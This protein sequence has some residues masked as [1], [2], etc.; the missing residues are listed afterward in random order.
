MSNE[1]VIGVDLGGTK[2]ESCLMDKD[3]NVLSRHRIASEVDMGFDRVLDNLRKVIIKTATGKPYQAIGMGT[4]G[5][6][7]SEKDRLFGLPHTSLYEIPGFI[8]QIEK[9]LKKPLS[10]E[11][12]ANCLA[13]AE[14]FETCRGKYQNVMMVILGTGMGSGLILDNKLYRGATGGA[15]EIGHMTIDYNGR[16]C[17]CGRKG[18]GEAYLSGPSHSRRFFEA[19][20]KTVTVQEIYQLYEEGDPTAVQLFDES[21]YI[22]GEIFADIINAFDLEAIILGGGVSNLSIWYDKVSPYV[23]E[24]LFGAPRGKIP[25]LKAQLG[26]SAGVVGAAY[27]ALRK[28]GYM[29]F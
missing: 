6:Y 3:R 9:Q 20:G 10:I 26:D 22:M 1:F 14:F 23:Q 28:L 16:S 21:C 25:I 27:L 8:G 7:V 17:E 19:T 18:C 4:G 24:R 5:T 2:I 11:N 15:G 12:D 13:L 29:K